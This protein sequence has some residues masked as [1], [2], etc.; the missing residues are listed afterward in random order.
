MASIFIEIF[1]VKILY[2]R[3]NL[4]QTFTKFGKNLYPK[5]IFPSFNLGHYPIGHYLLP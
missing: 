2:C 1:G 3:L 4:R 5:Q